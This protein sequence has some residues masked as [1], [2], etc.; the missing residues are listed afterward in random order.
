MNK[1]YDLV[2]ISTTFNKTIKKLINIINNS[3]SNNILFD[4]IKRRTSLIIQSHPLFLLEEAGSQ[5]FQYRDFI[6]NESE[7]LFLELEDTVMNNDQMQD[8]IKDNKND[9]KDIVMLLS[10]I[11]G[12]WFKYSNE[13]KKIIQGMLKVLLSEYCKFLTTKN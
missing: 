8:Y 7:E 6:K 4:T 3:I 12:V 2:D 10:I 5:I 11:K 1:K 9:K 13:E